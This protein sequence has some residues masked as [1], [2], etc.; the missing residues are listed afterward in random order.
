[1]RCG[2]GKWETALCLSLDA[3]LRCS[4]LHGLSAIGNTEHRGP[5]YRIADPPRNPSRKGGTAHMKPVSFL[6]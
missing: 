1:M 6:L 2:M 5:R 4:A 3:E